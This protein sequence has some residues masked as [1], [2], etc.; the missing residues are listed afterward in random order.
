MGT[1][2]SRRIE[3]DS[4]RRTGT[5]HAVY[6]RAPTRRE[7]ERPLH[8]ALDPAFRA[9]GWKRARSLRWRA[10]DDARLAA[11]IGFSRWNGM[12]PV[13]NRC[14]LDFEIGRTKLGPTRAWF[15][16]TL[17]TESEQRP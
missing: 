15:Y 7:V 1:P 8:D 3:R 14:R 12:A 2:V 17:L 16:G 11:Q 5:E 10:T 13:P 4:R 9:A 6:G